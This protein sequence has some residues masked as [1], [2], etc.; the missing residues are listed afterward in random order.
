MATPSSV[1]LGAPSGAATSDEAARRP[2][3]VDCDV[4][5]LIGDVRVLAPRLSARAARRVFGGQLGTFARD[6]N[7][8]PHPTSGLRLHAAPPAGGPA[9]SDPT[10][11]RA[12]WMDRYGISAAVLVPVQAGLTIPWGD[13]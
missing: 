13:E 4:P 11:A 10:F 12:Q 5:P 2:S 9:G 1:E 3:L 7:R 8:I 6:P